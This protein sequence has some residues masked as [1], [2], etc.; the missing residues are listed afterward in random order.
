[1]PPASV[2]GPWWV[3]L[4]DGAEIAVPDDLTVMTR[5]VL[6]EQGDW[7]ED[8]I[9]FVRRWFPVGGGAVDVGANFGVYT[10]ALAARGGA[11]SRIVAF[12][13]TPSV[14]PLLQA[15]LARNGF[16][17]AEV[18]QAAVSAKSGRGRLRLGVSSELSQLDSGIAD[19]AEAIEVDLVALDEWWDAS[20]RPEVDFLKIDAEGAEVD[21][22]AGA[23]RMIAQ[24]SPLVLCELMHGDTLNRPMC[25]ALRETGC[26]LYRLIPGPQVLVPFDEHGPIDPFQMNLLACDSTRAGEL[27]ASEWLTRAM[28][29]RADRCS[30]DEL[31]TWLGAHGDLPE[32][33]AWDG[34]PDALIEGMSCH[35]AALR[36]SSSAAVRVGSMRRA[37]EL[38]SGIAE[39]FDDPT[40]LASCAEIAY[41]A[42]ARGRG[43]EWMNKAASAIFSDRGYRH[44]LPCLLRGVRPAATP[45]DV[46]G[47]R[48]AILTRL[49]MKTVWSSCFR[50]LQ[51]PKLLRLA[52]A[53]GRIDP[54]IEVR[55]KLESRVTVTRG[56][57]DA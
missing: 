38:A 3:T 24:S 30:R 41:V 20:G 44:R 15:S 5:W 23:G 14:V 28:D 33:A 48:T 18:V 35:V 46:L 27:E 50:G 7:F 10:L 16:S 32:A 40:I 43:N 47:L 53:M 1:M 57:R 56:P 37:M 52:A 39:E 29:P 9:R 12:E 21:V 36:R 6:E 31:A 13:P 8:E 4:P 45:P 51:Q 34:L 19:G 55:F 11:D 49:E 2:A 26:D 25:K 42:G 22:L 54:A 17:H